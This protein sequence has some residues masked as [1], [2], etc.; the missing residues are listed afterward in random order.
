MSSLCNNNLKSQDQNTS[1]KIKMGK[2]I[3][4]S[5]YHNYY[6]IG[7]CINQNIRFDMFNFKVLILL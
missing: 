1:T 3:M 7:L 2:L 4:F 6:F 5:T